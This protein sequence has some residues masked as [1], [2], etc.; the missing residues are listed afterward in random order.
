MCLNLNWRQLILNVPC[1]LFLLMLFKHH[2]SNLVLR[3]LFVSMLRFS[4]NLSRCLH[5]FKRLVL[6]VTSWDSFRKFV[7]YCAFA[8]HRVCINDLWWV[9]IFLSVCS[10]ISFALRSCENLLELILNAKRFDDLVWAESIQ[11]ENSPTHQLTELEVKS[12]LT[13]CA[14]RCVNSECHCIEYLV[15]LV[16]VELNKL[17]LHCRP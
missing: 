6:V 1:I 7:A 15:V 17:L 5:C 12:T 2:S 11:T 16:S 13:A 10:C 3:C 8:K 4:L 14:H 9:A